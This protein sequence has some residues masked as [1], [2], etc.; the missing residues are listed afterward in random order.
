[1]MRKNFRWALEI[2]GVNHLYIQEVQAPDV[3]LGVVLHGSPGNLP[4]GK[5][6]GKAKVGELVAKM[7]KPE[8]VS[9]AYIWDWMAIAAGSPASAYQKV[10]FLSELAPDGVTVVEKYYCGKIWPSKISPSGL[11]TLADSNEN[12]I[13]TVTF[14]VERFFS[15]SS[16]L[17]L[18]LFG[19]SGAKA[20]GLPFALGTAL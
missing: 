4:D 7:C 13:E 19:G 1:M 11:V 17:W 16:P 9:S 2:Q 12:I 8:L 5:T 14:Q 10:G 18:A 15:Q 20:G 3:E 6:A